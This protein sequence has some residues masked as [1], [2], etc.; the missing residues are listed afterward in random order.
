META[1]RVVTAITAESRLPSGSRRSTSGRARSNRR[2][3]R[4]N[5]LAAVRTISITSSSDPAIGGIRRFDPSAKVAQTRSH[6]LMS[7]FS[8]SGSSISVW[9]PPMPNRASRTD[10][11]RILSSSGSLGNPRVDG[12]TVV[13]GAPGPVS[14]SAGG[15]PTVL[16]PRGGRCD[17]DGRRSA[18]GRIPCDCR[19]S[20]QARCSRRGLRP[21]AHG[22]R[23]PVSDSLHLLAPRPVGCRFGRDGCKGPGFGRVPCRLG[24][25]GRSQ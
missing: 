21:P 16:W 5:R 2:S 22:S 11:A 12:A 20:V 19:R 4:P 23:S 3:A 17:R 1:G 13:G 18:G 8:I 25:R 7:M 10:W 14:T 15:V 9:R 24:C 6:P